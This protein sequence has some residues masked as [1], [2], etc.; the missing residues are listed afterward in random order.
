MGP[1]SPRAPLRLQPAL[2]PG[3]WHDL[4]L[5][6]SQSTVTTY[7]V[8]YDVTPSGSRC[9]GTQHERLIA[10]NKRYTWA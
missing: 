3:R 4:Y 6:R 10:L 8:P 5:E 2:V 1:E 7:N 9:V